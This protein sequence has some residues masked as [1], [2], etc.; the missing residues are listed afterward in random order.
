MNHQFVLY[1]PHIPL[2]RLL[3]PL[4]QAKI[5]ITTVQDTLSC[6]QLSSFHT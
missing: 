1:I 6:P 5:L 4:A 3:L 2:I